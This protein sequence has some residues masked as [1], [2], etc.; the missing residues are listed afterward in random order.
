MFK[1]Y[2]RALGLIAQWEFELTSLAV[3]STF[4]DCHAHLTP[5]P[6]TVQLCV[7]VGQ[8]N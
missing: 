4:I 3:A 8:L 5:A 2:D 1:V 6:E 7:R